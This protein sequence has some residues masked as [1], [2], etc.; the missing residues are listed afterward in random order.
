MMIQ[1]VMMNGMRT[2]RMRMRMFKKNTEKEIKSIRIEINT[3]RIKR[4]N[5]EDLKY[6]SKQIIIYILCFNDCIV[7]KSHQHLSDSQK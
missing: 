2:Q 6:Q 5:E 7:T 3:N 4:H 1:D